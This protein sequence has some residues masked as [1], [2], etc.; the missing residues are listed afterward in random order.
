[1]NFYDINAKI[2]WRSSN[3]NRFFVAGYT[4][5]DKITFDGGDAAFGWGNSTV[6]FR[7]NHLFNERLFSNTSVIASQFDYSLE[8]DEGAAAFEW[9]SNL[10]ELSLK[11]DLTYFLNTKNELTFGYH[12]T[13][14][15]FSP[16]NITPKGEN[17]IFTKNIFPKMYALDHSLFV[18]NQQKLNEK[19]SLEYGVRLSIFQNVGKSDVYLYEDPQDNADATKTDTLHYGAWETIKTYVNVEPRIGVRYMISENQSVKVSYNRMTQNTHLISAGTI[20]LPFNTWSPSNYYLEPQIA[21]Q[22]AVGYFRNVRDNM[23]EVAVE[24]YYK[25]INNVTDFADNAE[26]FLNRDISTEY[27]QGNSWAYGAEFMVNKKQ[28]RLTGMMTYT[29][30]KAMRKIEGVNAG[31]EFYASY[32][33]THVFNFVAAYDLNPKWSFGASFTYSTGRPITVPAGKYEYGHYQPDVITERNGFRLPDFHHL[34]FSATLNPKKNA[35]RRFKGQ[36]VFSIY[37]VY[38][39]QNAFS[40]YSRV[41]QDDDG[42]VIGDGTQKE[43][44]LIYL[45]PILPFVTYNFKF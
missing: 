39:R 2:N 38:S 37:N 12:L 35:N 9:T 20:P 11:N 36:W 14:R 23:F 24:A 45:F 7:W 5:R 19:F 13:G 33:R 42:N 6:T 44:R 34:D 40:I 4:G 43:T 21:D 17:S 18:S 29:W 8:L 32:D 26:L 15:R 16:A 28:G 41:K 30:S 27:R 25:D 22:F 31:K 1:V 3:K 10:Q